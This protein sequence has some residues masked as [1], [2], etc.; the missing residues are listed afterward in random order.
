L[1]TQGGKKSTK[2]KKIRSNKP[3]LKGTPKGRDKKRGERKTQKRTKGFL[4]QCGKTGRSER[5]LFQPSQG[6]S[7]Y[8]TQRGK[9]TEVW[10]R[11]WLGV[12]EGGK[13]ISK[14]DGERKLLKV[15]PTM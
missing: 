8:P 3:G 6:K 12:K 15:D 11:S 9:K 5:S 4:Y 10:C 2:R 7:S 1:Y 13:K 14:K